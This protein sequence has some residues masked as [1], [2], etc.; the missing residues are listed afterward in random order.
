MLKV[1][2][3]F[4]TGQ[5]ITDLVKKLNDKN[6][7]QAILFYNDINKNTA[8]LNSEIS[9]AQ[10]KEAE[11]DKKIDGNNSFINNKVSDIE[12][13]FDLAVSNLES[14]DR[15]NKLELQSNIDKEKADREAAINQ[16]YETLSGGLNSLDKAITDLNNGAIAR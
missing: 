3:T 4:V 12:S 10:T 13:E 1:N 15:E 6:A 14:K 9:R 5:N 16:Q 7:E 8:N 11:L 2:N